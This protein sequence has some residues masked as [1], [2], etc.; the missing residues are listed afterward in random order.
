MMLHPTIFYSLLLVVGIALVS[1][2]LWQKHH[3]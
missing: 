3:R 2:L 1:W